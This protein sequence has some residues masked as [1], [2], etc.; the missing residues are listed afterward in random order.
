MPFM[1]TSSPSPFLRA[2]TIFLACWTFFLII[3]GGA[4]TST[5]SGL[6]VPDWPL[7]FGTWN[8]PMVGGVF[9]EHGHRLIATAAGLMTV[10]LAIWL[11]RSPVQAALKRAAGI[12]VGLV[13]LQ[14]LLGGITVLLKL[15]ALTSVS[16]ACL[17]QIFFSWMVCIAWVANTSD[18]ESGPL[19]SPEAQKM[20]RIAST[21]TGFVLLQLLAGAIYRHTGKLLHF[22]MLGAFLVVLHGILV[23]K[24][25]WT[26]PTLPQVLRI[27]ASTLNGFIGVQLILGLWS[28]RLPNPIITTTHQS[29]GALI[30]ATS[31]LLTVQSTRKKI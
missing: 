30:L 1:N 15:P 18:Y 5:G 28:W 29:V 11:W 12:A 22:H 4:V 6:S 2:Y 20:Y 23:L 19:L 17:G 24:R 3:A 31:L 27:L 7:S 26:S 16:H 14:G 10:I 8:P 9:F 25:A 21:T 13:L